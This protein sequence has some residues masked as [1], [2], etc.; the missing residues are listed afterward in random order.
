VRFWN[1]I[2][3][4]D[5][6]QPDNFFSWHALGGVLVSLPQGPVLMVRLSLT[7]SKWQRLEQKM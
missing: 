2:W 6:L 4:K 3:L 5:I 1:S 7:A